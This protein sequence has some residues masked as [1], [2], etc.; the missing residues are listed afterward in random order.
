MHRHNSNVD[1]IMNDRTD[2]GTDPNRSKMDSAPTSRAVQAVD[3]GAAYADG[4]RK[5]EMAKW[6]FLGFFLLFIGLLIAYL[7]MPRMPLRALVSYPDQE[8]LSLYEQSY[9][10]R[11][12]SR[13]IKTTWIGILGILG[14][15]ICL[16]L[17]GLIGCSMDP[18]CSLSG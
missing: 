14:V 6:F 10:E 4:I 15:A 13:R 18:Y 12:K 8:N 17:V 1:S 7:R 16:I 11:L 3:D 2:S 5:A 9:K